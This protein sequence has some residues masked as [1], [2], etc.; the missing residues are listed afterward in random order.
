ME[1][2]AFKIEYKT[3]SR[4]RVVRSVIQF[5]DSIESAK[6]LALV[7]DHEPNAICVSCRQLT[8]VETQAVRQG[9]AV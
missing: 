4:S 9:H 7:K 8:D 3:S 1:R 6:T 5:H 2:K